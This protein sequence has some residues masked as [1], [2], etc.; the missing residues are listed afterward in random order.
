VGKGNSLKLA[1]ASIT[2]SHES[3]EDDD[4]DDDDD[5]DVG[6]SISE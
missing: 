3:F 2:Q 1:R 5:S 4:D 6:L